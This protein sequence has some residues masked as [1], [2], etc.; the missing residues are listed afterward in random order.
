MKLTTKMTN[1]YMCKHVTCVNIFAKLKPTTTKTLA[2]TTVFTNTHKYINTHT[3]IY[4][5]ICYF[6]GSDLAKPN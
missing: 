6:I 4:T 2:C 5:I 3:H 1:K